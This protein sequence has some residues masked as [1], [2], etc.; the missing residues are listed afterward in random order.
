MPQKNILLFIVFLCMA[1]LV[2]LY[3]SMFSPPQ[4]NG[5]IENKQKKE[6]ES[7]NPTTTLFAEKNQKNLKESTSTPEVSIFTKEE[8]TELLSEQISPEKTI[9]ST[10]KKSKY[11]LRVDITIRPEDSEKVKEFKT[12][13]GTKRIDFTSVDM[14]FVEVFHIFGALI[15]IP[16][17]IEPEIADDLDRILSVEIKDSPANKFLDV[18][19]RMNDFVYFYEEDGIHITKVKSN[20]VIFLDDY[21]NGEE[22]MNELFPQLDATQ[23]DHLQ[24]T[25]LQNYFNN[26][27]NMDNSQ[28]LGMSYLKGEESKAK[29]ILNQEIDENL[30][31]ELVKEI[32]SRF[33]HQ[34][35]NLLTQEQQQRIAKAILEKL[36]FQ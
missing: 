5:A 25:R 4:E 1:I 3:F 30:R 22:V 35:F 14:P 18:S 8:S 28:Q 33:F 12:I 36:K 17:I 11:L 13:L 24:T 10:P 27:I 21:K 23:R 32:H 20:E 26:S 6:N 2:Y 7:S 9:S 31:K 34:Y 29:E 15:G 16:M 19:L